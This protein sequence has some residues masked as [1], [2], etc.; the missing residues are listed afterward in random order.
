MKEVP[1]E[2]FTYTDG[3]YI[4]AGTYIGH[5]TWSAMR[6]K[7][8]FGDDADVF[9]PDRFIEATQERRAKMRSSVDLVFGY[10][11]WQCMGRP[12]SMMELHKVFVEVSIHKEVFMSALPISVIPHLS[13]S[14]LTKTVFSCCETSI[15]SSCILRNQSKPST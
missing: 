5:N 2:G 7:S 11:R 4:P 13:F 10:G 1:P 9:R 6:D 12:I 14:G 15:F 3:R 8:I